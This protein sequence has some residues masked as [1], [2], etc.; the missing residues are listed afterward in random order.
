M[1]WLTFAIRE[2]KNREVRKVLETLG[3]RVNRLIRV[4][5]RAVQARR[6]APKAR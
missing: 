2:G 5:L 6:A 1:C 3:L 4:V